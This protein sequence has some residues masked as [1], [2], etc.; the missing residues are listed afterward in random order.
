MPWPQL[1]PE[2]IQAH[3]WPSLGSEVFSEPDQID[4]PFRRL[5]RA[6]NDLELHGIL[7]VHEKQTGGVIHHQIH[8]YAIHRPDH[9]GGVDHIR[10]TGVSHH[11]AVVSHVA[12]LLH[13]GLVIKIVWDGF[14]HA[15]CS[16]SASFNGK[17]Q[18][19]Q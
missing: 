7:P 19:S 17:S 4:H 6:V 13:Q 1:S 15:T 16:S 9:A 12:A 18:A 11:Q 3:H 5:K 14:G 10:Q 8:E 2:Q